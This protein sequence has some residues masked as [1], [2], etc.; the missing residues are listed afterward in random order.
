MTTELSEEFQSKD[1]KDQVAY[2]LKACHGN[3]AA[4]DWLVRYNTHAHALD[5]LIDD[6]YHSAADT[7]EQREEARRRRTLNF[8]LEAIDLFTHPFYFRHGAQL[9][10]L[11]RVSHLNYEDSVAWEK[12]P[13]AWQRQEADVIRHGAS[14]VARAVI[15]LCGGVAE[16]RFISPIIRMICYREHHD[17]DGNPI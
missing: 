11:L 2:L 6:D 13:L 4:V 1:L 3:E 15:D 10:R 12:S 14:D 7:P 8:A 17:R 9:H 16:A 5:D